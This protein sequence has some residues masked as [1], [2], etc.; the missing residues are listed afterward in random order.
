MSLS[1]CIKFSCE[2]LKP[3]VSAGKVSCLSV[4][5]DLLFDLYLHTTQEKKPLLIH[6]GDAIKCLLK[7]D[8]K[9]HLSCFV[10]D[11]APSIVVGRAKLMF[12][13]T[14]MGAFANAY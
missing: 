13:H 12:F 8:I 1:S 5:K 6:R 14:E 10:E 2:S 11:A 7:R 4:S 3:H 9:E